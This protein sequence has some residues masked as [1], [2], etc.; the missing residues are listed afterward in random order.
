MPEIFVDDHLIPAMFIESLRIESPCSLL[1]DDIS[2]I[3]SE[4]CLSSPRWW[5][6]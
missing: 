4:I 6:Q 1:V 3:E 5:F 2:A